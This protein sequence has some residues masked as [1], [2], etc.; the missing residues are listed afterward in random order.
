[1]P[2]VRLNNTKVKQIFQNLIENAFKYRDTNKNSYI[3]INW[4]EQRESILFSIEDNGIG[5]AEEHF[6]LIFNV[7]L[8]YYIY[9]ILKSI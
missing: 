9:K 5:I 2:F 6:G 7:F 3:N 8:Y 4:Q 1:M